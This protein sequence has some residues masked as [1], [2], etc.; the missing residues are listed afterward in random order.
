MLTAFVFICT[1]ITSRLGFSFILANMVVGII[2]TNTQ[3]SSFVQR[4]RDVLSPLMPLLFLLFFA[5]AGA[6]LHIAALPALG[7]VGIAYIV[8]RS[9]GK[10]GGATLGA[11]IG[12]AEKKLRK[13]S[14]IGILSQAGVA[15]GLSLVI[16]EEFASF[17]QRGAD[18]GTAILTTVTATS[19]IFEIIGPILA[20]VALK[21]AGEIGKG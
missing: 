12:G 15:I 19:I 13:Y 3:T 10:I 4:L 20:R 11:Y 21:R 6:N 7:L 16:K 9:V 17:G 5:L 8:A 18:I 2:I 1:G 14:G